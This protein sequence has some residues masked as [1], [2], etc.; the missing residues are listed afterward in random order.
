MLI[1][2]W[3]LGKIRHAIIHHR[4]DCG[5]ESFLI[6]SIHSAAEPGWGALPDFSGVWGHPYVPAFEAPELAGLF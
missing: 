2:R 5:R 3:G 1:K 6:G 4:Y